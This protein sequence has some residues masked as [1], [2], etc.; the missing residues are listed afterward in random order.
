VFF[1]HDDLV[2]LT[3][4]VLLVKLF[5]IIGFERDKH[6]LTCFRQRG[7]GNQKSGRCGRNYGMKIAFRVGFIKFLKFC[8]E[9]KAFISKV[10]MTWLRGVVRA[11]NAAIFV[12]A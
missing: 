6:L 2:P 7:N 4:L 9:T 5:D 11:K 1:D 12:S 3:V 10:F 8:D